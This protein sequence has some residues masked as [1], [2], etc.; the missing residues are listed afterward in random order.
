MKNSRIVVVDNGG[1]TIK[2]GV[3]HGKS[4]VVPRCAFIIKN[5]NFRGENSICKRVKDHS[6]R[7]RAVQRR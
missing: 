2:L 5:D 3:V 6:E 7:C 4:K 1:S